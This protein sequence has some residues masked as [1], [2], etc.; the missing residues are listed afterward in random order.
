LL[1]F[2]A[3]ENTPEKL[4]AILKQYGVDAVQLEDLAPRG[5]SDKGSIDTVNKLERT[6]ISKGH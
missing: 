6:N 4:V 1:R 2:L 3:G 5:I